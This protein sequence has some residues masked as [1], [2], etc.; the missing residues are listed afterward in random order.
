MQA[1]RVSRRTMRRNTKR[2]DERAYY[3]TR[4]AGTN[5]RMHSAVASPV[6]GPDMKVTYQR[7]G[8]N[9]R[10]EQLADRRAQEKSKVRDVYNGE[11]IRASIAYSIWLCMALVLGVIFLYGRLNII[12]TEM[13]NSQMRTTLA[14]TQSEC[15][16][17]RADIEEKEENIFVG[18]QAVDIGLVSDIGVEKQKLCAPLDANLMLPGSY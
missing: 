12:G 17:L 2:V 8:N 14:K 15:V 4:G 11:G 5:R 1:G 16:K 18:Y 13:Q 10:T 9:A 7:T 6:L 3:T